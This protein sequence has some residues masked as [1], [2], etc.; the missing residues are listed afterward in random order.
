MS[1]SERRGVFAG[2]VRKELLALG[3]DPL[4]LGALF[5]LPL[6]FIVVMTLALQNL[7]AAPKPPPR[8]A[9]LDRD[10]GSAARTL[11]AR[12]AERHG[13]AL[14]L[15]ADWRRALADGRLG[16]VLELEPGLS[17]RLAAVDAEPAPLETPGAAN[18]DVVGAND[19]DGKA[20]ADPSNPASGTA[21][22][23][24]ARLWLEPG[25]GAASLLVTAAE[26]ERAIGQLRARLLIA[27]L[28][29]QT[30]T[31]AQ[32]AVEGY[33]AVERFADGPRPSAVQHNVPAWL[34]FGM[35]FV[36]VALGSLFVEERQAG[37]LARLRSQGVPRSVLLA[38]KALP[39]L[40]V[41]ALQ[42]A[43]MLAVGLWLLPALGV[44]GLSLQGVDGV[45]LVV[46]IA[47]IA[48]AAVGL[49]LCLASF[50]R[51]SAQAHAVGPL[52]NVLMAAIGGIMVPTFVMP[53]AMQALARVSPMHWALEALLG[54]LVRG[55]PLGTLWP[56]LAA[57][58]ALGLAGTLLAAWPLN[59][60]MP[61]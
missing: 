60:T 19:K 50:M 47:C 24:R 53:A 27:Q 10:G 36:V 43:G 51:S 11:A 9:L 48:V 12:W 21:G 1:P 29:G 55:A 8:Y 40:G 41:N 32:T 35:F 61:T 57:L 30:P 34:V 56:W 54:V 42:A 2:L 20:A 14:A 16:Y 52:I 44:E 22:P 28:E 58:V 45:A 49:G 3:R 6:V 25:A 4:S 13:A 46:V 39:Y 59:R 37:T 26:L 31:Q 38:S 7:Y 17:Q 5:L 33:V 23:P 15:P 18:T